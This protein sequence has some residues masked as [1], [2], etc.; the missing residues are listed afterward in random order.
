RADPAV[1]TAG[2]FGNRFHVRVTPGEADAVL[3]R[4]RKSIQ[5]AGGVVESLHVIE[6]QLEDVFI[7]LAEGE[8][9][10]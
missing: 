7:E 9:D 6:P 4:L 2:R 5:A 3:A 10:R 1:E 8:A